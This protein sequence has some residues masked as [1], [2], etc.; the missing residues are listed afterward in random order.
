MHCAPLSADTK[1]LDDKEENDLIKE[2]K[3]WKL[4]REEVHKLTRTIKT[5]TFPDAINLIG[6]LARVSQE[7]QHHPD[8]HLYYNKLVLDLYSHKVGGLSM[9][10]FILAAKFD[11]IIESTFH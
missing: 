4:N 9:N 1:P 6:L 10:D 8:L 5:E 11:E 2:L 7:E 3:E